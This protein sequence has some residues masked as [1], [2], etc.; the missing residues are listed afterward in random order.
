MAVYEKFEKDLYDALEKA[1]PQLSK[2][3]TIKMIV[4]THTYHPKDIL[5]GFRSFCEQYTFNF[6]VVHN[7]ANEPIKEGETYI[8]LME[9]DLVILLE[10]ILARKMKLG[11]DVGVISYNDTPL[12]RIILKGITTISTDFKLMGRKADTTNS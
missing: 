10:K 6:K 2:Y 7:I 11:K 9:D 5:N 1:L 4:P 12:K 8:N 3:H